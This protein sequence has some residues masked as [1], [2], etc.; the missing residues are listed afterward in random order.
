VRPLAASLLLLAVALA[1]RAEEGLASWYA[2]K[3]QGRRTASGEIF[4]TNGMTAAHRTLPFGTRVRVRNLENGR[5]VVVRINDRG[6]FVEG[7]V[8]DLSRAAAEA[9]AMTGR[10]V[11]RVSVEVVEIPDAGGARYDLQVAA[12]SRAGNAARAVARLASE[13]V[14]AVAVRGPDGVHRVQVRAVAAAD[15]ASVR[16]AAARAGFSRTIAAPAP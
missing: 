11:A 13:G 15:L 4:D 2:G 16:E 9:I 7:R 12:F 8:I 10:G 5:D 3:F 6:P 14:E 1:A